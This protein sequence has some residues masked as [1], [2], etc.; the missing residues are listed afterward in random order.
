[1][2][3][4]ISH[5]AVAELGNSLDFNVNMIFGAHDHKNKI[6]V[7]LG[8][9]ALCYGMTSGTHTHQMES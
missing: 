1:M 8:M 9:V 4:Q 5:H 3:A 6:I 2:T 7:S